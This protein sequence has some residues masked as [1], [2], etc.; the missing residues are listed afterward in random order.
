MVTANAEV[1]ETTAVWLEQRP[2]AVTEND[3][4]DDQLC[5]A[6]VVPAASQ[7][8]LLLSPQT[9][10]YCTVSPQLHTELPVV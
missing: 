7:P 9:N 5:E 1:A 4:V 10:S 2:C 6:L 8:V 3:P